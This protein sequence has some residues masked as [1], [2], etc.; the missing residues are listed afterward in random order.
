[1]FSFQSEWF[2]RSALSKFGSRPRLSWSTP[3]AGLEVIEWYRRPVDGRPILP[4]TLMGHTLVFQAKLSIKT[5]PDV[6]KET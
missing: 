4:A 3:S 5:T 2:R 1:M 6:L